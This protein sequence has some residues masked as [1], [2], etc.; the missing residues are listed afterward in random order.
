MKK[1]ISLIYL[2]LFFI[3][4]YSIPVYASPYPNIEFDKVY[5][6]DMLLDENQITTVSVYPYQDLDIKCYY[7]ATALSPFPDTFIIIK[8]DNQNIVQ[9]LNSFAFVQTKS[10]SISYLSSESEFCLLDIYKNNKTYTIE[11]YNKNDVLDNGIKNAKMLKNYKLTFNILEE[12]EHIYN[13]K[14]LK[15]MCGAKLNFSVEAKRNFDNGYFLYNENGNVPDLKNITKIDIHLS[16]HSLKFKD[17]QNEYSSLNVEFTSLDSN[18]NKTITVNL[19]DYYDIFVNYMYS[20]LQDSSIPNFYMNTYYYNI[21]YPK[22]APNGK[23]KLSFKIGN[24]LINEY[25]VNITNE[26]LPEGIEFSDLSENHWAYDNIMTLAHDGIIQGYDDGSFKPEKEVTR[27]ELVQL[28]YNANFL[29][30]PENEMDFNDVSNDRWSYTAIKSY[31]KSISKNINGSWFFNPSA[32]ITR[33]ETAKLLV[34][35][36][37]IFHEYTQ[38]E[39]YDKKQSY[40]LLT[41]AFSN[42]YNQ[43]SEEY[44]PYILDAF[45]FDLMNGTSETTFSPTGSLTRAQAATL[46]YRFK[47]ENNFAIS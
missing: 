6:A 25:I 16:L 38:E 43:M 45:V 36:G 41:L 37:L 17:D 9:Q 42:D 8:D 11:I 13:T 10:D 39:L 30:L 14:T 46:I 3:L 47:Y 35:N 34:A 22:D 19:N 2:I 31:G 18:Y 21:D 1:F 40:D 7:S 26:F 4:I 32:V 27:E 29:A 44:K 28:M 33:Q 12:R 15:C 24:D 23:M 20:D 5:F